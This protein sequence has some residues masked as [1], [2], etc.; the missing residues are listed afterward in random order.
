MLSFHNK[1]FKI[2]TKTKI[3]TIFYFGPKV[4]FLSIVALCCKNVKKSGSGGHWFAINCTV[5]HKE[6]QL[7]GN[8]IW[9]LSI[10]QAEVLHRVLTWLG[11]AIN[12]TK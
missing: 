9:L 12:I 10:M 3:F 2:N 5:L 6:I 7:S 11:I 1:N 4:V 8:D